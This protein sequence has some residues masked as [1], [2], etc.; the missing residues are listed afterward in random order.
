MRDKKAFNEIFEIKSLKDLE[1]K[2]FLRISRENKRMILRKRVFL[3]ALLAVSF[4]T[5]IEASIYTFSQFKQSGFYTYL[6]VIF[7]NLSDFSA[8]WKDLGMVLMESLPVYSLILLLSALFV[9]VFALMGF[10]KDKKIGLS[11]KHI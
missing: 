7:L 2:V 11:F 1:N 5:T 10:Y 8:Y 4:V 9:F 6:S 3:L